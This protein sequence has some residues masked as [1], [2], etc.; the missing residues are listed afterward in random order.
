MNK[1]LS[2]YIFPSFNLKDARFTVLKL[3]R[4]S[5]RV[6]VTVAVKMGSES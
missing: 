5:L 2:A 1:N 6:T 4:M 3:E